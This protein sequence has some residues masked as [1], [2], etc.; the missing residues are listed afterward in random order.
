MAS[1]KQI[2]YSIFYALCFCI[3][4]YFEITEPYINS[5]TPPPAF[6]IELFA[7]PIGVVL[8]LIDVFRYKSTLVHQIGLTANVVVMAYI[9]FMA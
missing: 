2:I 6:I 8:L 4:V 9:L 1:P 3:S 5:H 7:I